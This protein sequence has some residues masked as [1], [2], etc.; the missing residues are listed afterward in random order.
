MRKTMREPAANAPAI[1]GPARILVLALL[2]V[3]VSL[4]LLAGLT[5]GRAIAAPASP[6]WIIRSLAQPTN[7]SSSSNA[8]CESSFLVTPQ[9]CDSYTLLATNVGDA[10][11]VGPTTITD[12]LPAGME[13]IRV[14]G[15]DLATLNSLTCSKAPLQCVDEASVP[16]GD[17]LLMT[18]YVLVGGV[19]PSPVNSAS[20]AGGGAPA[21]ATSEPTAISA[22][23]A[24]F[25]V[26]D[27]SMQA[28]DS[29]GVLDTRAGDHPANLTTS[30]DLTTENTATL[31]GTNYHPVQEVRDVV[32]YL[33]IG[34]VGNPL[35][36]PR[37]P[38]NQL[39]PTT[40]IT[41]CPTDS[42]IGT[43]TFEASPG[44]FRV[45]EGHGSET[46]AVYNMTPEAGYPAEL[47]FT[48]LGKPVFMYASL[49]RL[50]SSYALR[51]SVPGIPELDTIGVSLTFFGEPAQRNG[52]ASSSVPFF[53]NPVDCT[54]SIPAAKI[55]ADSWE[56]PGDWI[57]AFSQPLTYPRLTGCEMLQFHPSLQARPDTTQADEPSGYTFEIENPQNESPLTP[58]TP[59][60][61]DAT[62]TLPAGVSV[63]PAAADGLEACEA[64][65]P[66]GIDMPSGTL[67]PDKA[68]E[69]EAIGP[70]GLSHLTPGHCPP[71]STVG[72][73]EITTPLL[74][75]PL[76][77][78]VFLG[79]PGCGGEGQPACTEEDAANGNLIHVYLEA[80]GSGVVVKLEGHVSLNRST[81]RLTAT[82]K[83]N[84]QLPFAKLKLHFDGG[85]RA[86]L[87]N[88]PTCGPATT[89]A[90]LSPWS[91]PIT[92]DATPSS[93]FAVD[94]DGQGGAVSGCPGTLPFA[95]SLTAGTIT[96]T[97]G[98]FSPFTLT[99]RR[100]DREQNLSQLSVR[101]PPGLLGMLSSVTLCDEQQASQGTCSAA[102]EI[103]T[104]RVA[105][106]P[107]SHP[108]WVTGHVFLTESYRGAPFGLSVVVPAVAGPFNLGKVVVRAMIN[109][110][111]ETSALTITSDPLPQIVDGIPLRVQTVNVTVDRP[112][113]M[114]NPTNCEAKQIAATVTGA[115]GAVAQV[116]S[117]FAAASCRSLPFS[118]KF[119]VS[120]AART[121]KAAGA[122]LDVKVAYK[123]GQANIKS[124]AVV[125]PKQLP[126]RLTTIQQACLAATFAA[127]PATCPPGS[128]IGIAKARTPVLPVLLTG[129][130]YL[131]SHGGAAFPDVVLVL[132][133]DGVRIDLRGNVN[134]AK[135]VTS[136]TFASV[137]DAPI[138]SFEL[139]LPQGPHSALATNL[140]TKARGNFCGSKLKMPTTLTAQNGLQVRQ[141]TKVAISGC[142]KSKKKP[143]SKSKKQK[144]KKRAEI[145]GKR[146][147]R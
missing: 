23:A 111:P 4:P 58:G 98:A 85:P 80:A 94:W 17:T 1:G 37:C 134:I 84:P 146:S 141:S 78:H 6:A 40:G 113:F 117:P 147:R 36:A 86:S 50:G 140:P 95:P 29:A 107:G 110:D 20:V 92:P 63:S 99:L 42:R 32:V 67:R 114:F 122:S 35:A 79:R 105:A 3:A 48:Y 68:G 9:A 116:S 143:K 18:V 2:A 14:E 101:T 25:G 120:S 16:V 12:F 7:F 139:N 11:T 81:G 145:T 137:P 112:G 55:E 30:F 130:A 61:K 118:P 71:G 127:N 83:E 87:A 142:P 133:G 44:V 115:R 126:A 77:G 106:G 51:V 88:P 69:G 21:V 74:A 10:D 93:S 39:L 104:T 124:V 34:L 53:T 31:A 46:T 62:V 28:L 43:L 102:S 70:D 59:E 66:R 49:V 26:Q 22:E 60:L 89:S 123:P 103:G 96:P 119:T 41:S 135:G 5:P 82:F 136:S 131:V 72:S 64:T 57:E 108:F 109:V 47:G 76:E 54:D 91:A 90:D 15:E 121:S 75:S 100:V 97:A 144:A 138:T 45:S 129:P 19:S 33:P 125:L 52:G 56:H 24:Q 73:V 132:Q 27:F 13:A 8:A 38:L 65:G 128:L